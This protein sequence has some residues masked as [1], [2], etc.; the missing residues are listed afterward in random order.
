MTKDGLSGR[1][2]RA[3][4]NSKL[5]PLLI[6]GF[7]AIGLYS[8]YLTPSEEEPQITVPMADIFVAYPGASPREIETKITEPL[9]K[10]VSSIAGVEYVYSTSMPGQAMLIVRYY[11]GED[12]ERSL[13][14][15]YN[16]IQKHMDLM[17]PGMNPPFIKTKS[18]DD[19]PILALTLWSAD[20][21]DRALRAV[22]AEI[23]GE[24]KQIPDVG[25]TRLTGG[26]RR[27]VRVTLDRKSVV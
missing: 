10:I 13:F 25:E 20:G 11:V 5:T 22:A 8:I 18:I 23:A 19:V 2:A 24:I 3:F 16:E 12:M 4:I 9:E 21:D 7:M 14:K 15:L 1:I 17:P 26:R 6:V 27:Q